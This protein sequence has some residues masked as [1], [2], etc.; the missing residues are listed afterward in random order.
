[1]S[2]TPNQTTPAP[3]NDG[4]DI[5]IN[6]RERSVDPSSFAFITGTPFESPQEVE[7]KAII[8]TA[9][10]LVWTL[11]LKRVDEIAE[12]FLTSHQKRVFDLWIKQGHTYQ[13]IGAMLAKLNGYSCDYSAY[14]AIS[15]CIKGIRSNKHGGKYH[16]GIENRLR[17][18]CEKDELFIAFLEDWK[19]LQ[20]DKLVLC[21]NFLA[22][23]DEWY[24]QNRCRI[25]TT[26][27]N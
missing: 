7:E 25:E 3:A 23:H 5:P 19:I 17:K 26:D 9:R 15:H 22:K 13:E 21:L 18:R 2:T 6:W 1:M 14:T 11:L 8:R 16:G 20:Q 4:W 10:Q 12:I 27:H 24:Q